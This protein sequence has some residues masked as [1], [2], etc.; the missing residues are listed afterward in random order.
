MPHSYFN[1]ETLAA[2]LHLTPQQVS[3]LADRGKLPG[4]KVAGEWRF[5]RPEIHRWFEERIGV[6]DEDGLVEVEGVLE[7]NAPAD[8][9]QEVSLAAM[10]PR[11]A[12]A[13]PLLAQSRN[14]VIN[15]MVEL[16]ASTGILWDPRAM[17]EAVKA[18]EDMH[19]TALDGGVALMHPRRPMAKIL[20]QPMMALGR[21]NHGIPFG[22][23]APLTD[24]FFLICSTDDRGHLR[25]LARLSRLLNVADFLARLRS[26]P[27]AAE[28]RRL[29]VEA[30]GGL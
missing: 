2:F 26:A 11:E 6:A 7:R 3:R 9:K 12:V 27:D 14:S 4:R 16:A 8:Q 15:A 28:A 24:V 22:S 19:P 23:G 13:V 20:S 25:V 30:E 5:S 29:I 17:A 1:V 18:R 21:T 10:L